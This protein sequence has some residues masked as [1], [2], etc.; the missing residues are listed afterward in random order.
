MQAIAKALVD[1]GHQV[2]WLVSPEHERLVAATGARFAP[3]RQIAEVDAALM[4]EDPQTALGN[5]RARM[6]GRVLAEVADYRRVLAD[7]DADCILADVLPLGARAIEDLGEIPVFATLGV[8]PMGYSADTCPQWGSGW[9]PP[10]S[11]LALLLNRLHH[12]LN[13]WVFYPLILSLPFINPQRRKLRLGSIALGQPAEMYTYSP[14]LHIQASCAELEYHDQT[15]AE[16]PTP[17]LRV[18]YVGPLVLQSGQRLES[19]ALPAW[20][21]GIGAHSHVV[22]LTQGTLAMDP[23]VLIIPAIQALMADASLDIVLVVTTPFVEDIREKLGENLPPNLHLVSW[24]P[25]HILLPR[26]SALVTNGG[27]GGITQALTHGVPVVCAGRTEDKID[28]AARV[29]WVG[30]GI[31]LKTNTPSQKQLLTAVKTILQDESYKQNARRVGETL[32]S[33][34]GAE[35]ACESLEELVTETRRKSG[36]L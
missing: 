19:D 34:G 30:A 9:R 22:G 17:S 6:R 21:E 14:H 11:K 25:Y 13:H 32:R 27:Y 12:R 5:A 23:S 24:F 2:V 1:R 28:T 20:W 36:R 15:V 3:T 35:A 18:R 4:A 29:A 26:L 16:Q 33:L 10:K 8:I 31:D 7:F